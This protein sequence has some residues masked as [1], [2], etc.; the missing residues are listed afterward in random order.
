[1]WYVSSRS[2]VATL[3]TTIHLL[4]T[5]LLTPTKREKTELLLLLHV[6]LL[7]NY[8]RNVNY[9][10]ILSYHFLFL[11]FFSMSV[12]NKQEAG[13]EIPRGCITSHRQQSLFQ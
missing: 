5:Y 3:R 6:M 10:H 9:E 1:M 12:K 4:L 7:V 2:G 8:I 13:V 11:S